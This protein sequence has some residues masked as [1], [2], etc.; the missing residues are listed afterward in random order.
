MKR[1]KQIAVGI[2]VI[3]TAVMILGGWYYFKFSTE[4]GKMHPS[5]SKELVAGVYAIKDSGFMNMYLVKGEDGFVA[6]DAAKNPDTVKAELAKLKI[7]PEEVTA[8]L[9]THTD[10][11]HT[12]ALKL[13]DNAKVYIS[14]SEEQMINGETVRAAGFIKNALDVPY[15]MFDDQQVK[16]ISGLSVRGILTP[17]HTPG[18]MS[19]LIDGRYLFTG[20]TLSLKDGKAELFNPFFNMDS[21]REEES[22]R[23]LSGLTEIKYL[24][25]AHYGYTD[26]FDRAMKFWK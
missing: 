25:T 21:A 14:S 10:S 15:E 24:F 11:D 3:F 19:Y 16:D 5:E 1:I 7:E 12:G 4:T 2:A 22:I 23:T 18:S 6:V 20:D 9:L 26:D 17:G 8:V 13:F